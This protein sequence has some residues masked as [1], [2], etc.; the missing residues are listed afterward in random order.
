MVF[1]MDKINV[2]LT[3]NKIFSFSHFEKGALKNSARVRQGGTAHTHKP[4]HIHKRHND[5]LLEASGEFRPK[6]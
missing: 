1:S 2:F 6:N 3:V 5:M 4:M